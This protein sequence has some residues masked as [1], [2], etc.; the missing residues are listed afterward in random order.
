MK[1]NMTIK[2]EDKPKM[3]GLG[4]AIVG[5]LAYLLITFI[6]KMAG[7]KPPETT[8]PNATQASVAGGTPAPAA[9][10]DSVMNDLESDI[11]PPQPKIDIFQPPRGSAKAPDKNSTPGFQTGSQPPMNTMVD[12]HLPGLGGTITQPSPSAP[13]TMTIPVPVPGPPIL[14]SGVMVGAG[15]SPLAIISLNGVTY[16]RRMGE[17]IGNLRIHSIQEAGIVVEEGTKLVPILV[18]HTLPNV[19]STVITVTSRAIDT[20]EALTKAMT[21]QAKGHNPEALHKID[22]THKTDEN[23]KSYLGNNGEKVYAP[24]EIKM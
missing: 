16:Y 18:G 7:E 8:V 21:E 17:S 6:P 22:A 24:Y 1:M 9:G 10:V 2:P 19:N 11:V 5:V 13:G 3:A 12:S 4:V 23:H 15:N 14:L 20:P